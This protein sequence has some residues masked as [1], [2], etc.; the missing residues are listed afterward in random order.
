MQDNHYFRDPQTKR[1]L[2][3]ILFIYA[4]L[5]PDVGY[6]QGMHEILAPV[7]WV[8]ESDAVGVQSETEPWGEDETILTTLDSRF[9]EHDSFTLFA[10]IMQNVKVLYEH[11]DGDN[12][13]PADANYESPIVARSRR[14]HEVM[15]FRVDYELAEHLA[16]IDIL[17]Q[18]FVT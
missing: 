3:D 16:T 11:G 6:R 1:R 8:V 10:A 14:I 4:K 2:L 9:I 5:N 7:M 18:I 12:G 17:P 13:K 15:L